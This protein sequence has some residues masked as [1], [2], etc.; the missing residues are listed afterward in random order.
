MVASLALGGLDSATALLSNLDRLTEEKIFGVPFQGSGYVMFEVL[1]HWVADP[2]NQVR[3][4][5]KKRHQKRPNFRGLGK[6]QPFDWRPSKDP[7]TV[8]GVDHLGVSEW[9]HT[10]S[11]Y[12]PCEGR[13]QHQGEWW[14]RRKHR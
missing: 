3:K 10:T 7:E 5:E 12:A 8:L 4:R 14:R 2:K 13:L 6:R 11:C 9:W 1:L